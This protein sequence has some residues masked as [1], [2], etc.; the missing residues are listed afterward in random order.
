MSSPAARFWRPRRSPDR[1]AL[2]VG[3]GGIEPLSLSARV[4]Q[5]RPVPTPA[6]S[7]RF[8]A[9]FPCFFRSN[10]QCKIR[11]PQ[12]VWRLREESNPDRPVRSRRLSPLSYGGAIDLARSGGIEPPTPAS[13]TGVISVSPRAHEP[14]AARGIRTPNVLFLRQAPL[15]V[16]LPRLFV[17]LSVLQC[18]S[19]RGDSN[20]QGPAAGGSSGRCVYQSSATPRRIPFPSAIRNRVGAPGRIRTPNSRFEAWRDGC[21]TT[22]V[23]TGPFSGAAGGIRTRTFPDL[24]RAPLPIEPPRRASFRFW[25]PRRD[26]NPHAQRGTTF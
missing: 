5:T 16:G 15:P 19:R 12:S 18:W 25:S 10:L 23:R 26:S 1:R 24:S 7:R 13:P 20:S 22:G 17:L 6:H 21:F 2:L 14:G 4:L 11:H 3:M 9:L 8:R